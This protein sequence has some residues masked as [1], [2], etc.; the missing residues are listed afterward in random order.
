MLKLSIEKLKQK[1][2]EIIKEFKEELE[3]SKTIDNLFKLE[4]DGYVHIYK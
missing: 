3:Y 4:K 2:I 1:K